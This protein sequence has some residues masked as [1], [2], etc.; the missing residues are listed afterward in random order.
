[1]DPI[2]PDLPYLWMEVDIAAEREMAQTLEDVLVRRLG[3]FYESPDQGLG[4]APA[5]AERLGAHLGWDSE[6]KAAELH[7]YRT[8][9]ADH[10]RFREGHDA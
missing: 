2:A 9:V 8:R 6:R 10:R 4:V 3:L 5:V 1:M 7:A